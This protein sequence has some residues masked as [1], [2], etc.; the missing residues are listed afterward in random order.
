[1]DH[2]SLRELRVSRKMPIEKA[3]EFLG[4]SV[5]DLDKMERGI[6]P[7][8]SALRERLAAYLGRGIC[9][10][11]VHYRTVERAMGMG[12]CELDRHTEYN[13]I[14]VRK[15]ACLKWCERNY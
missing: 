4:I 8:D 10:R 14:G 1:M 5:V 13:N 9:G 3:A 7:F 6:T 2:D 15:T 12:V 11:C